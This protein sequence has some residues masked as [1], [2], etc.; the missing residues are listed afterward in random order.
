MLESDDS[1]WI[2][3]ADV[4]PRFTG[5]GFKPSNG[6][7]VVLNFGVSEYICSHL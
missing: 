1:V 6:Q 7:C 3:E 2:G 4:S 5:R